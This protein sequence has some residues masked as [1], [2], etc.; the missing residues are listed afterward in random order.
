MFLFLSTDMGRFLQDCVSGKKM[1]GL[2]ADFLARQN[3]QDSVP[4]ILHRF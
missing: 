2:P 4:M 1:P 3:L